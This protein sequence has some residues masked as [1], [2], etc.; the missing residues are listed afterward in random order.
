MG[1]RRQQAQHAS[2][3]DAGQPLRNRTCMLACSSSS[4]AAA[5]SA[6]S[7]K[8]THHRRRRRPT[9]RHR[10]AAA[11]AEALHSLPHS[12]PPGCRPTAHRPAA[13]AG[14]HTRRR[15]R[16]GCTRLQGGCGRVCVGSV[17]L[18]RHACRAERGAMGTQPGLACQSPSD[19][20]DQAG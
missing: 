1:R 10:S 18:Q 13:A 19:S 3:S 4:S 16:P 7:H 11:A 9:A 2:S 8:P 15:H 14:R 20:V 12:C 6:R 5:Q 17:K